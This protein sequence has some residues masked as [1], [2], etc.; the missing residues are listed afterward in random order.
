[1]PLYRLC[2]ACGKKVAYGT[3]CNCEIKEQKES[4][5]HYKSNR[6]DTREQEF[7]SSNSWIKCRNSIASHQLGLDIIE[8]SKGKVVQAETYHH[9][10]E[11]KDDWSLRLDAN[12]IVGLTKKN[13]IAIH[14]LMNKSSE[15]KRKVQEYLK[16][17]LKKF[18][19]EFF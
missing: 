17:I 16:G 4:Y 2:S 19:E 14:R 11:T 18:E 1:M 8:W 13:H 15:N 12:N 9:I 6:T 5:K 3:K 7:Y 10:I